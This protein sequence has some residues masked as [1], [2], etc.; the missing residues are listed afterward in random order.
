VP[1]FRL[2][3]SLVFPPPELADEGLL[4]VGGD[5]SLER[6][7]LAYRSGIFPWYS[8]GDPILWWSP[9]TRCTLAPHEMH[10]SRSLKRVLRRGDFRITI[11]TV[12]GEVIGS[13]AK[14]PRPGQDGTWILPEM[15]AAYC[16][17]HEAGYAHSF[18]TWHGGRLVGGLYGI[19]LGGIF[20]GESMFSSMPNASKAAFAAMAAHCQAWDLPVIDCQMPTPHLMRLGAKPLERSAYLDLLKRYRDRPTLRGRWEYDP[21]V[22]SFPECPQ[23]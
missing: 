22:P 18:E 3:K 9:E 15:K 4:A 7:L 20:F 11:D 14:A 2:D 19:S 12:F 23:K 8:E 21:T 10:V 1:I 5:L 17:L 6:L 16:K 13:C